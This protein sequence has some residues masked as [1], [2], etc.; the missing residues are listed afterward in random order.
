MGSKK[1]LITGAVIAVV[2]SAAIIVPA[3]ASGVPLARVLPATSVVAPDG[4]PGDNGNAWGHRK[5]SPE[6]PGD[7]GRG[8]A[9]DDGPGNGKGKA[10]GHHKDDPDFPGNSGDDE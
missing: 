1:L 4:A 3:V 5:D 10:W 6:F 7:N 8:D 2:A 9:D